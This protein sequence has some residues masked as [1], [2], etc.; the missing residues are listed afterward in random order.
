MNTPLLI[1]MLLTVS[2]GQAESPS[3]YTPLAYAQDDAEGGGA[4]EGAS[5]AT[6]GAEGAEEEEGAEEGAEEEAEPAAEEAAEPAAEEAAEP[7]AAEPAAEAEP[8]KSSSNGKKKVGFALS[9]A[10]LGAGG[11]FLY[12]STV[13][14]TATFDKA[15]ETGSPDS[16]EVQDLIAQ[17]N[18]AVM[19]GYTGSALGAVLAVTSAK[20]MTTVS[21]DGQTIQIQGRF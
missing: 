21:T 15:M 4:E 12:N 13:L 18:Q 3:H 2:E 20:F 8:A 1:A 16:T 5:E 6:E 17:T 11:Y 10:S 9:A 19:I 7:A 14:S